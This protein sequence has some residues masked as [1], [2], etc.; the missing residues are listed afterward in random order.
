MRR[1]FAWLYLRSTVAGSAV[2]VTAAAAATVAA[3]AAT[4]AAAVAAT[5]AAT[6]AVAVAMSLVPCVAWANAEGRT[7]D[8]I[9]IEGE[10]AMPQVLFITAREPYRFADRAHTVYLTEPEELDA[11][12][13]EIIPIWIGR[14]VW[15][16]PGNEG[17]GV[18]A[19]PDR[20]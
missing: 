8:E 15:F 19:T 1:S 10:I 20:R 13:T 12:L 5:A 4:V 18:N 11:R 7:L 3:T 14:P 9:S 2:A 6:V 16:Q 17:P